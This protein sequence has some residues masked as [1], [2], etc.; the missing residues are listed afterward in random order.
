MPTASFT[1][2]QNV[3][4]PIVNVGIS[5]IATA[6]IVLLLELGL[7]GTV[8]LLHSSTLARVV[9][10]TQNDSPVSSE[11]WAY[12]FYRNH[13]AN[14]RLESMLFQPHPTRGWVLKPNV[15]IWSEG[16]HYTT[17]EFGQRG[18]STPSPSSSKIKMMVLGDSQTFGEEVDD[19]F[20]WPTVLA[21]RRPELEIINL[22]TGGYGID[23]MYVTFSEE[24]DRW[25]PDIVVVAP[26]PDDF[27]RSS[28]WFR[29]FSKPYF[30]PV[31]SQDG[32]LSDLA[33]HP[34]TTDPAQ[35]LSALGSNPRVAWR[36][37]DLVSL[38][39]GIF[40]SRIVAAE[41]RRKSHDINVELLR[42]LA[43]TTRAHDVPVVFVFIGNLAS[44]DR[45][46]NLDDF[47]EQ[48]YWDICTANQSDLFF[49]PDWREI[50]GT[51]T[52]L[53]SH[54]HY[55]RLGN[56]MIADLVENGISMALPAL[57]RKS[58]PAGPGH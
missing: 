38:A 52:G 10:L 43:T 36:K 2:R 39:L 28:L 34:P 44:T 35:L 8:S 31:Y 1:V 13:V 24:F 26:V 27:Y 23:Q 46:P 30:A 19:L 4:R 14:P 49:C 22:G 55:K 25:K 47:T 7:R 51:R 56:E 12:R 9:D 58:G 37:M 42:R 41:N 6:L 29:D 11:A 20:P 45:K 5:A 3:L 33:Y 21:R 57:R 16:Y 32:T 50:S 54:G 40:D 53:T 17:N 18:P 48:T 15:S